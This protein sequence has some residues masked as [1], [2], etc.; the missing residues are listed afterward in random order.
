MHD[1]YFKKSLLENSPMTSAL[2]H[3]ACQVTRLSNISCSHYSRKMQK[4]LTQIMK[5]VP[6]VLPKN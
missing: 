4:N 5:K 3:L 6:I 1:S 2:Q